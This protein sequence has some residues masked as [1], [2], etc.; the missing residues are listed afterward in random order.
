MTALYTYIS[1]L[2]I[3]L[4][5]GLVVLFLKPKLNSNLKLL[6]SFSGA[7]LL[8]ICFLHLIPELYNDYSYNIGV[9]IL[10][11]FVLQVLLEYF[12]KGIEHGHYH[13]DKEKKIFPYALFLSLCLHS[14]VEGMALVESN[15]VHLHHSDNSSLLIG[16]LIHKIPV[17]I[18][19][20]TLL[21]SNKN[22][23]VTTLISTIIFCITAPTGLFLA[24]TYGNTILE[25]VSVLNA[26]AVGILLHVST[27][28]LFE[29]SEGHKF[30]LKKFIVIIIG[31]LT[32]ILI[33]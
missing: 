7:F 1:L 13:P 32:A 31:L 2:A 28:I 16:I 17:V 26:L 25:N 19:L 14:F 9:F 3:P 4:I 10:V 11:G 6:L 15:H 33:L 8:A 30:H 5:T 24:S 20:V 27:T 21:L 29:T 22:S 18:I 23:Y 12:S